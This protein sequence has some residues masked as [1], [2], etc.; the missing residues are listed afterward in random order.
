MFRCMSLSDMESMQKEIRKLRGIAESMTRSN[1][2]A[3][4]TINTCCRNL[5]KIIGNIYERN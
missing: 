2:D 1:Y 5:D 4:A 3:F